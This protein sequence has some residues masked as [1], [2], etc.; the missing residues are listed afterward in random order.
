MRAGAKVVPFA[1]CEM[2]VQCVGIRE[3][4]LAVRRAA[5]VFD[6]S[7]MG[8]I[9]THGPAALGF[10]QHML[11]N[12]VRRLPEGGAQYS[13]LLDEDGGILDDRFT[14]RWSSATS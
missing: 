2:P 8:E 4:H 10:L 12:D 6:V 14:Y 13:V 11:S 3:E 5:G 1:A 9:E 7:H